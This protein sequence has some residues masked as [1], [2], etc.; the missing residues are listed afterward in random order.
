MQGL[1]TLTVFETFLFEGRSVLAAGEGGGG[2]G[3]QG[4]TV[5]KLHARSYHL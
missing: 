1:F 3:V 4:A 2:G 5:L